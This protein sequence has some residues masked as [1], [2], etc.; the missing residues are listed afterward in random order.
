MTLTISS[1]HPLQDLEK[2]TTEKFSPVV[3]NNV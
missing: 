2:W 3:N 1:R